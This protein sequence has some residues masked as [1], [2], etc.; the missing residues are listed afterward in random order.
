M[1][2]EAVLFFPAVGHAVAVTVFAGFPRFQLGPATG[3][4]GT[5]DDTFLAEC[6]ET[7]LY[8][9]DNGFVVAVAYTA[10]PGIG[11]YAPVGDIGLVFFNSFVGEWRVDDAGGRFFT[12][13]RNGSGGDACGLFLVAVTS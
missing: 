1:R 2:V 13:C 5:V 7:F 4:V 11:Q 9:P 6:A 8:L 12:P 10:A 3:I